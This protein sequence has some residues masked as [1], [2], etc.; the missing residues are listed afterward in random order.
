MKGSSSYRRGPYRSLSKGALGLL[1]VLLILPLL[2]G[3]Q[4]AK[5]FDGRGVLGY[6]VV[7]S[8]VTYWL[9]WHDKRRAQAEG[10]RT[11]ESTLHFLE[12]IGGWPTA[13]LAQ[14]SFRHKIAKTRYQITFW[15]IVSAHEVTCFDFLNH[16]HYLHSAFALLGA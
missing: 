5:S 11:P 16:W 14:R 10:W 9:Y 1:V 2:A 4:L 3:I 8:G 6:F 12:F 13:F 15:T 7:I